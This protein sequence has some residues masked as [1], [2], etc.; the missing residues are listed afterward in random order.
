MSVARRQ[1]FTIIELLSG[2]NTILMTLMCRAISFA[3]ERVRNKDCSNRLQQIVR[4]WLPAYMC[5]SAVLLG[6][7]AFNYQPIRDTL[8]R[9]EGW[10]VVP[11][12]ERI[13]ALPCNPSKAV[14]TVSMRNLSADSIRIVGA[15]T[16]CSCIAA[17]NAYPA[18]IESCKLGSI[19]FELFV[20][21]GATEG[22]LLGSARFF[23]ESESRSPQV[24][25]VLGSRNGQ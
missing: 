10:L 24:V 21:E 12:A 17:T 15:S 1:A 2:F 9:W 22:D 3:R 13:I 8:L 4:K 6:V 18:T 7:A 19:T 25:F 20:P 14:A 16:S 5:S 23:I 11:V